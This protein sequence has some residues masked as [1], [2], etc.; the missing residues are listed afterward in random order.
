MGRN[1][2]V[3]RRR[4]GCLTGCL[5]RLVVLL[6]L[7]ALLFV[8]ATMTGLIVNDP[9][10]GKPAFST[11]N[12]HMPDL[13]QLNLQNLK[14]PQIN[15]S[16]LPFQMPKLEWAYGLESRGLSVK[17]LRAGSGEA[18]LV[19]CDGYT[20]LAGTGDNGLLTC[21]QLLLCGVNH[22]DALVA[23][24]TG[25]GYLGGMKDVIGFMKPR[26]LFY[27]DSVV[28]DERYNAMLQAA[29][30]VRDLQKVVPRPGTT[31]N[32]GR[33]RV[34]VVG[35]VWTSHRDERDDSLSLRVDYGQVSVLLA[36]GITQGGETELVRENVRNL[37]ASLLIC[38]LGGGEEGS[39]RDFIR[40][41][42]PEY[43]V[44]TAEKAAGSV[45]IRLI[46]EGIQVA[47]TADN[48]VMTFTSDGQTLRFL[49]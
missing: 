20:L 45:S 33:G 34:S 7:A 18:V 30:K 31:F 40:A 32:L 23:D 37:P 48:G 26:Y 15:L 16:G 9:V 13:T 47:S 10:T 1:S 43:A 28:K 46:Q 4:R 39:S 35:P 44:T 36:G 19:C 8:L 41:V 6:G 2:N 25:A 5:P 14:L 29:D 42:E 3:K 24:G 22:L 49:P 17:I 11:Q 27:Q 38:S 21:G 12:L